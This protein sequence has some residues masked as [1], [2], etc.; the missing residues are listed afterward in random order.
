MI[1]ALIHWNTVFRGFSNKSLRIFHKFNI[2][3]IICRVWEPLIRA[4]KI[5][6][7]EGMYKLEDGTEVIV[8]GGGG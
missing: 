8:K 5:R 2:S 6:L 3:Y 1:L 4:S 7:T